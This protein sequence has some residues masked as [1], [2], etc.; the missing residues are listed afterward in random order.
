[1]RL[2]SGKEAPPAIEA[3]VRL[4]S[5]H[6]PDPHAIDHD[7][8]RRI[9]PAFIGISN[10]RFNL[11]AGDPVCLL[12]RI[13]GVPTNAQLWDAGPQ[14]WKWNEDTIPAFPAASC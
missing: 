6:V 2:I 12:W 14:V 5:I 10:E 9:A 13:H 3:F 7:T 4:L 11:I 1:L 8:V